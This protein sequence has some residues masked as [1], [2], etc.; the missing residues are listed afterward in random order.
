MELTIDEYRTQFH[1]NFR[2]IFFHC[3]NEIKMGKEWFIQWDLYNLYSGIEYDNQSRK[4]DLS[5]YIEYD[6][7]N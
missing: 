5:L 2:C 3:E 1:H 4:C 6:I 7:L